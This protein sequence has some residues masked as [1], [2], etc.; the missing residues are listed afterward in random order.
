M[1]QCLANHSAQLQ[2]SFWSVCHR[3]SMSLRHT[4]ECNECKAKPMPLMKQTKAIEPQERV[5]RKAMILAAGRGI[6]MRP[7]TDTTPK[8]LIQVA[9]K[10]LIDYA[11]D[12]LD[13]AGVSEVVVNGHYLADQLSDYLAEK[14]REHCSFVKEVEPLETGGGIANVLGHFAAEPFFCLNSD[15][16]CLPGS[17][18]NPLQRMRDAWDGAYMDVLMLLQPI[19][20]SIGYQ[21]QGDFVFDAQKQY[22]RRV[23]IG[24]QAEIVFTGVQLI[25][26]RLFAKAP[27]EKV[28]SMNALYEQCKDADGWFKRIGHVI[29][30]GAWLHVGDP[31]ALRLAE[32]FFSSHR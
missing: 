18:D 4:P 31:D 14:E 9:G 3:M 17:G 28:F 32:A 12:L 10:P 7:L 27:G 23:G 11:F 24:E 25:H 1:L 30:D 22:F 15:T 5:G 21:G 13:M 6:R 2:V 19:T 29:H 20:Q 16:I 26:P 8:P